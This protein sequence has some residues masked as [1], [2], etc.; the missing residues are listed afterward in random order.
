MALGPKYRIGDVVYS[1]ESATLGELDAYK[2]GAI[3]QKSPGVWVYQFYIEKRP[4][5]QQT[6]E[7]RI[8]L[9]STWGL[10]YEESELTDVCTAVH[11]AILN[12]QARINRTS[13]LLQK[14]GTDEPATPPGARFNL[15]EV[16]WIKASADI[17]FLETHKVIEIHRAPSAAE[18]IYRL[19]TDGAKIPTNPLRSVSAVKWEWPV[20]YFR[21][22]E[23]VSECEALNMVMVALERKIS[24]LLAIKLTICTVTPP[25][26]PGSSNPTGSH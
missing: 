11:L 25:P 23:L 1:V 2:I 17:G 20:L 24:R 4:P 18:Y 19:D 6:V 12:V 3:S 5:D 9:R 13:I 26:G 10:F 15:G 7:D 22:R 21:E 8:D 14:C 16:V